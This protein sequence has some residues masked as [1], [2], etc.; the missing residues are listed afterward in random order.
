MSTAVP[1]I[2]KSLT[3]IWSREQAFVTACLDEAAAEHEYKVAKARAYLQ[4]DGTEKTRE[5]SSVVDTETLFSKY[6]IAKAT[7]EFSAA[8]LRDAQNAL[9]ARQSIL[10]HE[11][12]SN[13]NH[14]YTGT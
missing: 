13:T 6:L 11:T 4:A 12:K 14:A 7:K 10:N 9:S 2:Q 3:S 1:D 5:A 8:K